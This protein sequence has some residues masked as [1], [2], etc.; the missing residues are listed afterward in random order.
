MTTE[1]EKCRHGGSIYE[2]C[3]YCNRDRE[4]EKKIEEAFEVISR[5]VNGGYGDSKNTLSNLIASE[6]PTLA[7]I[8]VKAIAVGIIRRAERNPDWKPWDKFTQLC[9]IDR[10]TSYNPVYASFPDE[11]WEHPMHDGRIDCTTV[12]GANLM[13]RQSYI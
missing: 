11:A 10:R 1:T 13:S 8:I 3:D 7:G 12:V 9:P 6:H 4:A 5:G 2:R